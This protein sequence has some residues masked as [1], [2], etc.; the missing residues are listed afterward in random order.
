MTAATPDLRFTDFRG[1]LAKS[2]AI[3]LV[4]GRRATARSVPAFFFILKFVHPYAPF[5]KTMSSVSLG[6]PIVCTLT[7][8]KT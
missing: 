1:V 3:V 8:R 4:L 5:I 6:K 7:N 2:A